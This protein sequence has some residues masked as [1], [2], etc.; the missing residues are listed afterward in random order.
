MIDLSEVLEI[1]QLAIRD[2]GG[3]NGLRDE[4]ALQ[5][6]LARPF[7]GFGETAFYPTIE[8]KASAVI[9]SIVCNHPF[10]DGNKRT[11]YLLMQFILG[12]EGKVAKAT[13]K[14]KYEFVIKIASGKMKYDK[15]LQWVR[16]KIVSM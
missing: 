10:L 12:E 14:E 9:E 1:H 4:A 15:I 2:F 13:Q 5:A 16:E 3:T 6:A 8:E 7:N 11:G